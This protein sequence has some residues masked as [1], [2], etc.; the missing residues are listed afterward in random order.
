MQIAHLKTVERPGKLL[1]ILAN[2]LADINADPQITKQTARTYKPRYEQIKNYCTKNNLIASD[3]EEWDT[4]RVKHFV[5]FMLGSGY[6]PETTRK[7]QNFLFRAIEPYNRAKSISVPPKVKLRRKNKPLIYLSENEIEVLAGH[8]FASQKLERVRD[9]FL[10]Q[11]YSGVSYA[12]IHKLNRKGL[13]VIDGIEVI[14]AT[15]QKCGTLFT[16]PVIP[17]LGKLLDKYEWK[18]PVISNAKYNAY[19]KEVAIVTGVDKHL[20]THDARRSAAMYYLRLTGSIDVCAAILGHVD[21]R[22]T[23]KTYAKYLPT[24][25]IEAMKRAGT[26]KKT[27]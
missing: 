14:Q 16:V 9:L 21:T 17:E 20:R 3:P 6:D 26:F 4:E 13:C 22:E 27:A 18:P 5:H 19:L 8:R 25:L 23:Y 2:I 1:S 7:T 11:C 12:D 24:H 10:I 15:R